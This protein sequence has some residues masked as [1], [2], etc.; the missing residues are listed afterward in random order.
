MSV[1]VALAPLRH[2]QRTTPMPPPLFDRP[3]R[4]DAILRLYTIAMFVIILV[5]SR[6]KVEFGGAYNSDR[7]GTLFGEVVFWGVLSFVVVA[8]IPAAI[9][10]GYRTEQVRNQAHETEQ[11][12]RLPYRP[13][14]EWSSA[15]AK[16][17]DI[18]RLDDD[19]PEGAPP[20]RSPDLKVRLSTQTT[21]PEVPVTLSWTTDGAD[22]VL[23]SELSGDQPPS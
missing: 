8:L 23:I 19:E 14:A 3:L 20:R 17:T 5:T 9:R 21:I 10:S 1:L 7:A 12:S 22:Y 11:V 4:R 2:A 15:A 18:P 6:G 16:R 13:R